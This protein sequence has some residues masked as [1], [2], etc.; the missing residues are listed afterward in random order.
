MTLK[1]LSAATGISMATI[2]RI[3]NGST[4]AGDDKLRILEEAIAASGDQKLQSK[5]E[6]A[7]QE[8]KIIALVVPDITNP[9]FTDVLDGIRSVLRPCG[10]EIIIMDSEEDV[11]KEIDILRTLKQLKLSGVIITPTS[12]AEE[13]LQCENLLKELR[14]PVIL[15]DR[16]VRN[17]SFDGVF[18]HN[19]LG[20]Y[21]GVTELIRRGHRNIGLIAGPYSSKP[22]RERQN[23]YVNAL[24][25]AQIPVEPRYMMPGDFSRKSGFDLTLRLLDTCPEVTAIFSSNNL[26][27]IG[28]LQALNQRGLTPDVQVAVVG[29]D[30]VAQLMEQDPG[31]TVV[32]R[33]TSEM[34]QAAAKIILDKCGSKGYASNRRITLIPGLLRKK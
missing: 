14:V 23:G 4:R 28:C 6:S 30:E 16:D 3:L 7:T 13:G 19:E 31:I 20:A 26:M 32:Q 9:F 15:V 21:N 27:T 33:P 24:T 11:Q 22:G 8:R 5:F 2:S 34:G 1:E 17:S 10:Y 29:F 25:D 12:D 18:V